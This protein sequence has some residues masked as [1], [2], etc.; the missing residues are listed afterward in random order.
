MSGA[1]KRIKPARAGAQVL[2][3]Q[4]LL[5]RRERRPAAATL[6]RSAASAGI[7]RARRRGRASPRRSCAAAAGRGRRRGRAPGR[8]RRAAARRGRRGSRSSSGRGWRRRGSRR[9]TACSPM[10]VLRHLVFRPGRGRRAS[11]RGCLS[12]QRSSTMP[13]LVDAVLLGLAAV[14]VEVDVLDRDLARRGWPRWRRRIPAGALDL[15]VVR[16]PLGGDD[17]VHRAAASSCR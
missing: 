4:L 2:A 15:G 1:R 12:P 8:R 9:S 7:L 17:D 16:L 10:N 5:G 14:L 3:E 6:T 13:G 11:G